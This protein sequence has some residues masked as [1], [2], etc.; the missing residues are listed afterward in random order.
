MIS[1]HRLA[2]Q[3][4][5]LVVV[6]SILFAGCAKIPMAKTYWNDDIQKE[7]VVFSG[8]DSDSKIRWLVSNDTENLYLTFDTDSRTSQ[9]SILMSGIKIY[10]DTNNKKKGSMYLKYPHRSKRERN[11]NADRQRNKQGEHSFDP[12]RFRSPP[13]GLWA[14]GGETFVINFELEQTDFDG[15]ISFDSLA[16]MNYKIC[17]PLKSINP[18]GIEGLSI[19]AIGIEGESISGPP[20]GAGQGMRAGG[21]GGRSGGEKPGGGNRPGGETPSGGMQSANPIKIWMS[22]EL[23]KPQT[24]NQQ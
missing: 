6:C 13:E 7:D 1:S 5:L 4:T 12:S 11:D 21:G 10:I 3:V 22:T 2:G 20:E 8:Y 23:A 15:S 17:I 16:F 9:M 19:F 24:E 18:K 14:C